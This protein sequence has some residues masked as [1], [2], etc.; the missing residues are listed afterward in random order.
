MTWGPPTVS[1]E[2]SKR[3][4]LHDELLSTLLDSTLE[5]Q[6]CCLPFEPER[7]LNHSYPP[8]APHEA[9]HKPHIYTGLPRSEWQ[10]QTALQIALIIH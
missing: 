3:R 7:L 8:A 10:P 5:V 1:F 4:S 9:E 6:I 2:S